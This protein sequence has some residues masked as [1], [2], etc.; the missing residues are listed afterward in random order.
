[1]PHASCPVLSR[2]VIICEDSDQL[3]QLIATQGEAID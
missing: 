2:S 1:M 3:I